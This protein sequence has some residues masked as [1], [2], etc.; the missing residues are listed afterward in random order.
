MNNR[1]NAMTA[2]PERRNVLWQRVHEAY[3]GEELPGTGNTGVM[4]SCTLR[5]ILCV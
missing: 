1:H 2:E 3:S 4:T 5:G